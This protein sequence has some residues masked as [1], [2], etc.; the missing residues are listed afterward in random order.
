M[1]SNAHKELISTIV[2]SSQMARVARLRSGFFYFH[3]FTQ[4]P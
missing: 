4:S 1:D 3:V 2:D